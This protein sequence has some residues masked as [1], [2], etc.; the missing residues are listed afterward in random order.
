MLKKSF[1]LACLFFFTQGVFAALPEGGYFFT[2]EDVARVRRQREV[3]ALAPG[4]EKAFRDAK[5]AQDRW[6][7][8]FPASPEKLS[9]SALVRRGTDMVK[10]EK[11]E[12]AVIFLVP[13]YPSVAFRT[14]LEPTA[15]NKALLREM[16][17]GAIG[18]RRK[19]NMWREGGIHEAENTLRFLS[20]YDIALLTGALEEE[21]IAEIRNEMNLIGHNLEGWLLDNPFS[22]MYDD[23]RVTNY[24]INFHVVA[25]VALNAICNMFP[26]LPSAKE[27][28]N[29]AHKSLMKYVIDGGTEDGAYGE[30]SINYWGVSYYPL[31]EFIALNRNRKKFDYA[32]DPFW[33]D[34]IL[35]SFLWRLELAGPDGRPWAVGDGH[36]VTGDAKAFAIGARVLNAPQLHWAAEQM[37]KSSPQ[38]TLTTNFLLHY[39]ASAKSEMPPRRSAIFPYAGYAMLRSGR[40]A[41]DNA[42]FFKFGTTYTG[43]RLAE[44]NAVIS[45]HAHQDAMMIELHYRGNPV[46]AD[47]GTRGPYAHW[48]T[49]GGF[50][51]ATIAHSTAGL[52]N[53]WGYDRRDGKYQEHVKD[54]MDF[55]YERQQWNIGPADTRIDGFGDEGRIGLAAAEARTFDKVLHKRGLIWFP[56]DAFTVVADRLESTEVQPYEWYF[57][58]VGKLLD[59]KNLVFGD[60]VAKLQILPLSDKLKTDV[61]VRGDA[62]APP[63]YLDLHPD[64]LKK[65]R[66]T[67]PRW[68]EFSLLVQSMRTKDADVI[69]V[70]MPFEGDK[71]PWKIA[72]GDGA[73]A[74]FSR[75]DRTI[76]V[77]PSND[78]ARCGVVAEKNGKLESYAVIDG[79][80]LRDN[81]RTLLATSLA[82]PVWRGRFSHKVSCAFSLPD[83]K[84]C[85][86]CR[87]RP[88]E[89]YLEIYPPR[90]VPGQEP[91]ADL[92]VKVSFFTGERPSEVML[93][94]RRDDA[95]AFDDP[96][97]EAKTSAWPKDIHV[98]RFVREKAA[99]EYDEKSGMVSV[100]LGPGAHQILWR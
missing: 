23:F 40:D 87:P 35:Q 1:F 62:G 79:T 75:D 10:Q 93:S 41:Q 59:R 4:Y 27:W 22:R 20:A 64:T 13:D 90:K 70:L 86:E 51:K 96:V 32:S 81:G 42:L 84:A 97:F 45:G 34:R 80:L 49:Y 78:D 100:L 26:G 98:D 72:S 14:L 11:Y 60:D 7:K 36:R 61:F 48:H 58:P 54:H 24:C 82:T 12:R 77:T 67:P 56:Q 68:D 5:R 9:A 37:L 88:G 43:R 65:P 2:P 38:E 30:G 99:F 46:L 57:T 29:S 83:R 15:E 3:P 18:V 85:V 91:E 17:L 69:H 92:W 95:P 73:A 55:T 71:N 53:V 16:L 63:Y 8:M 44:R 52:G 28:E 94:H 25:A 74:T 19:F 33:R 89:D 21:D 6:R 47:I 50:M 39:D 66:R 31:I 76:R